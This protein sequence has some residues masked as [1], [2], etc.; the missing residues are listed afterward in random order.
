MSGSS[1]FKRPRNPNWG[2]RFMGVLFF[3]LALVMVAFFIWLDTSQERDGKFVSPADASQEAIS[4]GVQPNVAQRYL[5]IVENTNNDPIVLLATTNRPIRISVGEL[6]NLLAWGGE[7]AFLN[8]D[9]AS[10]LGVE[11]IINGE[12]GS[13]VAPAPTDG[14]NGNIQI[15]LVIEIE[16]QQKTWEE[17]LTGVSGSTQAI[18]MEATYITI[19]SDWE[20]SDVSGNAGV[21]VIYATRKESGFVNRTTSLEKDVK[22]YFVNEGEYDTL[23]EVFPEEFSNR[24]GWLMPSLFFILLLTPFA[25]L[26]WHGYIRM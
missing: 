15:D 26:F 5:E 11:Q 14:S 23:R 6:E 2:N 22:F 19:P 7:S 10:G 8:L 4:R 21:D 20:H 9:E 18:Y 1:F 12:T 3:A 13:I 17:E 24:E 25:W 16:V